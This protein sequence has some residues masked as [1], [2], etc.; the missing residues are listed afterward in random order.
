MIQELNADG[1][2][3]VRREIKGHLNPDPVIGS[4]LEE[5]L[6]DVAVAINHVGFLPAIHT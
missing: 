3:C 2:T 5:L 4:V 1:L 6:Q